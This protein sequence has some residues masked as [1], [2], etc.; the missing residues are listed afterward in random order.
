[1]DESLFIGLY[2][3]QGRTPNNSSVGEETSIDGFYLI[4]FQARVIFFVFALRYSS[5]RD[6]D[7]LY[8]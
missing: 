7:W 6:N 3:D 2:W 5:L 4:K 8:S 1:M